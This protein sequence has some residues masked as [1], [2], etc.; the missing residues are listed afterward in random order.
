MADHRSMCFLGVTDWEASC[1][2]EEDVLVLSA[3]VWIKLCPAETSFKWATSCN[4]A[5]HDCDLD[6][7][8]KVVY[9]GEVR[10]S[11]GHLHVETAHMIL[12]MHAEMVF[13][14]KWENL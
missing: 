9:T 4:P 13:L 12:I 11:R 1:H 6:G 10:G 7:A 8:A 2:V 3:Y 5:E 14:C